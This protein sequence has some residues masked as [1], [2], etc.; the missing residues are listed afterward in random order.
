MK[1]TNH[2]PVESRLRR[3]GALLPESC[4]PYWLCDICAVVTVMWSAT[5]EWG[6]ALVRILKRFSVLYQ[7]I[8]T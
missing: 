7:G 2:L 8:V 5:E 6:I 4:V 3:R 1:L